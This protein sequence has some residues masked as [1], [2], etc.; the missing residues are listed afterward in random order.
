[1]LPRCPTERPQGILQPFGQSDEALATEHDMGVLKPAI[2]QPEVIEAMIERHARDGDAQLA[3]VGEVGQ[4]DLAHFVGLAE[5]DLLLL[6]VDRPP[7]ADPA[8]QRAADSSSELRMAPEHLLE[9]R[10]RLGKT[11]IEQKTSAL[12]PKPDIPIS[13]AYS[14]GYRHL[15]RIRAAMSMRGPWLAILLTAS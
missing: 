5:D 14:D 9:D 8:L 12:P 13:L 2:G 11:Q 4:A 1:M 15:S 7:G 6:A 3:H 10:N